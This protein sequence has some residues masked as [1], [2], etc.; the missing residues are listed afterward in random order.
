MTT[1][2]K[3][4]T[5]VEIAEALKSILADQFMIYVKARNYHWNVTGDLFFTL[6]EKFQELYEMLEKDIDV[7]AERIRTFDVYAPG[8]LKELQKLSGINDEDPDSY[9]DQATMTRNIISDI[10]FLSVR[11]VHTATKIQKEYEDETTA[12]ML[13][14]L[15]EKYD[16]F[17][18][19]LKS[20][21]I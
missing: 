12:S 5:K 8:T 19:M 1:A 21:K 2:T 18:W 9:P 17:V 13:Y 3:Q 7:I 10:E 4:L 14:G 11:I 16:K 6:H 20:L 15:A